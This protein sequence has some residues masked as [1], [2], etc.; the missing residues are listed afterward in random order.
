MDILAK[1]LKNIKLILVGSGPQEKILENM[2]KKFN[3]TDRIR[4]FKDVNDEEL[5]EYYRLADIFVLPTL[6][7]GL[8]LVLL[9]AA[10]YGLPIITTDITDNSQ[11]VKNGKNGYLVP[12]RNAPAI[13]DA[14]V[15][16]YENKLVSKMSRESK[17]LAQHYDWSNAARK[18]LNKY[19]EILAKKP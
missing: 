9:E 2:I 16:I 3:L 13:A 11:I 5:S 17:E 4:H 19:E 6:Y 15:R 7:E 8:P 1:R 18:A 14:V 10:A 12:T